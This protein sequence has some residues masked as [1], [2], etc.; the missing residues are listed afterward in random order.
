[1]VEISEDGRRQRFEQWEK[2]G[3]ERV[4]ADLLNGGRQLVG[5]PPEVIEL[6]WEWV[7]MKEAGLDA[8]RSIGGFLSRHRP[9]K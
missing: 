7:R 4:K 3:P 6:A 9:K 5:G 2:L 8:S 1:M